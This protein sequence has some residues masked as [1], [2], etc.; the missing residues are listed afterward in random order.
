MWLLFSKAIKTFLYVPMMVG[1]LNYAYWAPELAKDEQA[2]V[3][4]VQAAKA[5][6]RSKTQSRQKRAKT[7]PTTRAR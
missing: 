6:K 5:Q 1:L 4:S 7:T 3:A 2:K